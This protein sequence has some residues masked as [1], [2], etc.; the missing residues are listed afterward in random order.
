MTRHDETP[1]SPEEIN[2]IHGCDLVGVQDP[3]I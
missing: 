1:A 2:A 3:Q